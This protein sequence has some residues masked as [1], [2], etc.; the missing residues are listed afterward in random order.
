MICLVLALI[1]RL[2][3]DRNRRYRVEI[4][5][6]WW[7]FSPVLR[8]SAAPKRLDHHHMRW[9]L[10]L[11]VF[12]DGLGFVASGLDLLVYSWFFA[13]SVPCTAHVSETAQPHLSL[14]ERA[15]FILFLNGRDRFCKAAYAN[16]G[17]VSDET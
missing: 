17:A 3:F 2:T 12:V 8:S 14:G 9:A 4:R 1:V 11:F 15:I 7:S 13:Q 5:L 6:D 10:L 16:A